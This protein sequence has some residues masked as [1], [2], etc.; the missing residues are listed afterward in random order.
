MFRNL[1]IAGA[2]ALTFASVPAFAQGGGQ[3]DNSEVTF[4]R[5]KIEQAELK[6]KSGTDTMPAASAKMI[7]EAKAAMAAGNATKCT[8]IM[9]DYK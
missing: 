8:V 4:C 7:E 2:V 3:G 5:T 6:Y 9:K 1:I